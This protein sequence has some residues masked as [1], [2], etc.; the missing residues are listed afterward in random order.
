MHQFTKAAD[1]I[2]AEMRVRVIICILMAISLPHLVFSAR[3][4]RRSS[5]ECTYLSTKLAY[6]SSAIDSTKVPSVSPVCVQAANNLLAAGLAAS[7]AVAHGI[8]ITQCQSLY[9]LLAECFGKSSADFHFD[10]YCGTVN[11]TDCLTVR[12]GTTF[13]QLATTVT[14]KCPAS[15]ATSCTSNCTS[16]LQDVKAYSGCCGLTYQDKYAACNMTQQSG[17][18]NSLF[19]GSGAQSRAATTDWLCTTFFILVTLAT[20]Y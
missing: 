10:L 6:G 1:Q 13:T 2:M 8:C 16:A 15:N 14:G 3:V 4:E 11:G 19:T 17:C 18:T 20:M 12:N 5:D 7:A 9:D